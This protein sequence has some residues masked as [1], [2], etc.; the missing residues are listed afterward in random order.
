MSTQNT[1]NPFP[2]LRPFQIEEKFLFFG[3][4]EQ[5]SELLTRLRKTRFLAVVGVSGSGKSS[6]VRAG[7]LPELH[8]GTMATAGSSW[9]VAVMRPGGDPLTNLAEALIEADIHD[10][11]EDHIASHLRATL[12]RSG[13]GLVD[14]IKQGDLPE[15]TN[16]LLVVDQFEEIFRFR[17]MSGLSEEEAGHFITLL[18]EASEQADCPVYVVLTMRSD[19]LGDCAQF[20]GLAEAVNEGEYL[21]PRLNRNQRRQAIEGPVAVGGRE[22]SNRLTQRLLNDIGDDP[23]QLPILQHALMRTWDYWEA[24]GAQGPLDLEH[25]KATGGMTEAL[26]RHADEVHAGLPDDEHRWISEK[27]FKALTERVDQNRGI[28]RPMQMQEL[29]NIIQ[30]EEEK[31]RSVVD[32]FRAKGRT[33]LMPSGESDITPKTVIDISHESLMRVWHTLRNWVDD[34][35][36]SAKIYRRLADTSSLYQDG[37]AGLYRDP[38]LQIALSW[39]EETQPNKTWAN[40]YFTGFDEAM[41]FLDKSQEETEREERE[42]EEARQRELVQAQALAKAQ[43]ERAETEQLR[44][45]EQARSA[46]RLRKMLAGLA[47]ATCAAF[48]SLVIAVLAKQATEEAKNEVDNKVLELAKRSIATGDALNADGESLRALPWYADAAELAKGDIDIKKAYQRNLIQKIEQAP[49]LAKMVFLDNNVSHSGFMPTGEIFYLTDWRGAL[50]VPCNIFFYETKTGKLINKHSLSGAIHSV[51]FSADEK[52][53]ITASGERTA[54]VWDTKSRKIAQTFDKHDGMIGKHL[55][56]TKNNQILAVPIRGGKNGIALWELETG[57]EAFPFLKTKYGCNAVAFSHD[58]RFLVGATG[59]DWFGNGNTGAICVW[60]LPQNQKPELKYRIEINKPVNQVRFDNRDYRFTFACGSRDGQ[61]APFFTQ[62]YDANSGK[63]ISERMEHSNAI[64]DFEIS[65]NGKLILTTSI[66]GTARTWLRD[67]GNPVSAAMFHEGILHDASFSPDGSMVATSGSDNAVRIWDSYSGQLITSPLH[68]LGQVDRVNFNPTG[69]CV[70]TASRDHSSRIY[71]L[72]IKRKKITGTASQST[73]DFGGVASRAIDGITDGNYS[74]QSVTHTFN[75]D[76]NAWWQL[77]FEEPSSI[78]EIVI[79]NRS[80]FG[81]RLVNFQ[82]VLIDKEGNEIWKNKYLTEPD[83]IGPSP[84]LQIL[85]PSEPVTSKLRIEKIG[86]TADGEYTLSLAEVE[87][88][89]PSNSNQESYSLEALQQLSK[90][91]SSSRISKSGKLELLS[92]EEL[93]TALKSL[94]TSGLIEYQNDEKSIWHRQRSK[95]LYKSKQW[96]GF[97]FHIHRMSDTDKQSNDFIKMQG[98]AYAELEQWDIALNL[99]TKLLESEP[100]NHRIIENC[101][102]IS[103]KLNRINEGRKILDRYIKQNQRKNALEKLAWN[104]I[105]NPD[106]FKGI[107]ISSELIKSQENNFP[108]FIDLGDSKSLR[109][110]DAITIEGW[111]KSN[112]NGNILNKGGTGQDDGYGFRLWDNRFQFELQ[113]TKTQ[114]KTVL[115][116]PFQRSTEWF[117]AAAVWNFKSKEMICYI[118][119]VAQ[120]EKGYFAGPI[121]VSNQHL[122]LARSERDYGTY[123]SCVGGFSEIRI[124]NK[125]RTGDEIK[126]DMKVRLN[127]DESGLV[128]YWPLDQTSG[129]TATSG[130]NMDSNNTSVINSQWEETEKLPFGNTTSFCKISEGTVNKMLHLTLKGGLQYRNGNIQQSIK[131][132]E[133]AR[134]GGAKRPSYMLNSDDGNHFQWLLLAQCYHKVGEK[135]KAQRFLLLAR[136]RV[137]NSFLQDRNWQERLQ[138]RSLLSETHKI[139]E[140]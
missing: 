86:P 53:F 80:A 113:N 91:T 133:S 61:N 16:L 70:I 66:D 33:F 119:G 41:S 137:T 114:E 51:M 19:F 122:N 79:W 107:P 97:L 120:G 45:E 139:L 116:I 90:L 82:V 31:V 131:T 29:C 125:S 111:F 27:L 104:S 73:T 7:L 8:G 48:I 109:L 128:G 77:N 85:L 108:G 26:S 58:N 47:V 34:E 71:Q 43:K 20:R 50:G 92:R 36:Q 110:T 136:E 117:H 52:L 101:L 49:R 129:D 74:N 46:S 57:D 106:I 56:L 138:L 94:K 126:S 63:N 28:R 112:Q 25:Y 102:Y 132:L 15:R 64:I 5:T 95:E 22:I 88:F 81:Y 2:G 59:G 14:A 72:P 75:N 10:S 69:D 35:A 118:N 12:G 124:W 11:D 44:A 96:S 78:S 76:K 18:L 23:D 127:G 135:N 21:I 140:E 83:A 32:S 17:R 87:V 24:S 100:N 30:R 42:R 13:K 105:I 55:G 39:R 38:D 130:L 60:E 62:T 98:N 9:E 40:H 93:K 84:S 6:L 115:G 65:P 103:S 89:A 134:I 4:E 3:R 54:T 99:Y 37:K 68:H 123:S 67:S 1:F 121:G